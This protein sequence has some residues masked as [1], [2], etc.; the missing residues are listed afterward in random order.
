MVFF[1]AQPVKQFFF[2]VILMGFEILGFWG[3]KY[4]LRNDAARIE[5]ESILPSCFGTNVLF[6]KAIGRVCIL[7]LRQL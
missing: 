5:S 1:H 6:R 4:Q 3:E 7:E 2:C